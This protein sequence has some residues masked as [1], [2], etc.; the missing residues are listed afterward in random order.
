MFILLVCQFYTIVNFLRMLVQTVSR[1]FP[2]ILV[3]MWGK[4]YL[5]IIIVFILLS[6]K[7][8]L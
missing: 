3:R 6:N 8:V 1:A 7:H 4:V 2:V 5:L